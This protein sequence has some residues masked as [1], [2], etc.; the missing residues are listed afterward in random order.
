MHRRTRPGHARCPFVGVISAAG[1]RLQFLRAA[2]FAI[3]T[4][5]LCSS[6]VAAQ[7]LMWNANTETDLAGYTV[8]YGTTSGNPSTSINVGNVTS[9]R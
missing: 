1:L 8:Q 5:L 3:L 2:S 9:R 4:V 7:T 6:P